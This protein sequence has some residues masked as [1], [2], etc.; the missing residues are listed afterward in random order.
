MTLETHLWDP[1]DRLTTPESV[2]AYL[3][4]A[5]EDGDPSLI[6]AALGDIAR[7]QGATEIARKAGIS[8]EVLYKAFQPEGNPTL[9]SVTSVMKA[10]GFQLGVTVRINS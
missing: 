2:Q 8:R 9:F 6:A 3:E 4:A 10:L 1:A 5:F 7:A